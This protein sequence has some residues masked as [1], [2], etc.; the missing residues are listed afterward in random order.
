M[1]FRETFYNTSTK[2]IAMR[3][4]EIFVISGLIAVLSYSLQLFPPQY[5]VVLIPLVET[6]LKWLRERQKEIE[7]TPLV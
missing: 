3:F 5:G 1:N 6:I 4:L 2:R 7:T